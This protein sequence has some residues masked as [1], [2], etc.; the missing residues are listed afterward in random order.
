MN[1]GLLDHP[2][3]TGPAANGQGGPLRNLGPRKIRTKILLL[4]GL[5]T[6]S[7]VLFAHLFSGLKGSFLAVS[8]GL[9][10]LGLVLAL[11]LGRTVTRPIV[12]ITRTAE[13]LANGDLRQR[14]RVYGR[15]EVGLLARTFNAMVDSLETTVRD[16]EGRNR[17]LE[18]A[19]AKHAERVEQDATERVRI[20][21]E[22][23]LARVE[24]DRLVD[25]RTEELAQANDKLHG[26]VLETRRSEDHL[27]STLDRLEQSLEGTLRAMSLILELRDPYMAGHQQRVS[28]LAVAIGREMNLA[29]D[30]VE[31][32]R[33]AG[34][35][36]DLG[37]IA[38]PIE[39]VGKPGRLSLTE[40]QIVKDHPR[41]GYEMIK[42]VPFPWPVAHIVLQHHERLDGSGYPEG[43]AGDAILPEARILGLADVVEALCSLR[44]YRPALGIEK[45]LEEIRKGRGFRYDARAVDA[46]LRL[47]R[48]KRFSFKME[49]E[50]PACQ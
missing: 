44:P 45:A 30:K 10:V 17:T 38:A 41:I 18:D 28:S 20:E 19:A 47:F 37:K 5:L 11:A 2:G 34:I 23:R 15:D 43:L 35:L 33:V 31:G 40:L 21:R 4:F 8:V 42:D 14:A 32:L 48:D 24:I 46:C 12:Q 29:W 7:F 27:Q 22:L 16:F 6:L 13:K 3:P 39:I 50:A 25:K 36:H 26:Q 1:L 9:I 49:A